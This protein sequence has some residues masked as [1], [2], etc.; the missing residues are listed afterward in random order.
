M[1]TTDSNPYS[2]SADAIRVAFLR[3]AMV[4]GDMVALAVRCLR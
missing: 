4:R 1:F 3:P 2:L